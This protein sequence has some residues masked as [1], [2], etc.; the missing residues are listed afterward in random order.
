LIEYHDLMDEYLSIFKE[1]KDGEDKENGLSFEKI[2][3]IVMLNDSSSKSIAEGII[4]QISDVDNFNWRYVY[5][6]NT[7]FTYTFLWY[8]DTY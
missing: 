3:N 8:I 2:L 7:N 5:M 4:E 6:L 1:F